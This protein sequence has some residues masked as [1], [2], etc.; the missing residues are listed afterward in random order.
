[1][2]VA[3]PSAYRREANSYGFSLHCS[4]GMRAAQAAGL[5]IDADAPIVVHVGTPYTWVYEEG[6]TNILW[7]AYE[8]HEM[9]AHTAE[10]ANRADGFLVSS[11]FLVETVNRACPGK[12]VE[13]AWQGIEPADFPYV[14]RRDPVARGGPFTFLWVGASSTRKGWQIVAHAWD[15]FRATWPAVLG[16]LHE[17]L[18]RV[19]ADL[20]PQLYLKT[21]CAAWRG[22]EGSRRAQG[23]DAVFDDRRV[24][25]EELCAIYHY[26]HCFL[27]PSYGEGFARTLA[28][29]CSTGLPSIY[30]P[31]TSPGDWMDTQ[32]GYPVEWHWTDQS[33]DLDQPVRMPEAIVPSVVGRMAQVVLDYGDA[34][35][36]AERAARMVR[37]RFSWDRCGPQLVGAIQRLCAR[38]GVARL[39]E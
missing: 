15:A 2:R 1:M 31:K 32:Y 18:P 36:R 19:P 8:C 16:A 4:D 20:R 17:R 14:R 39:L 26:A 23:P 33:Y 29:A 12:P 28:E 5:R 25:T 11:P 35:R 34:T 22:A 38:L 21:T 37:R 30:V 10:W 3:W 7:L 24:S 13:L 6:R 9:P 27:F